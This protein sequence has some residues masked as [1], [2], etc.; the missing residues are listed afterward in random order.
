MHHVLLGRVELREPPGE[1]VL[2]DQGGSGD[3]VDLVLVG[4][5]DV[6]QRDVGL[7]GDLHVLGRQDLQIGEGE[8][9]LEHPVVGGHPAELLV[10]DQLGHGRIVA[11]DGAVGV[12]AHT[13]VHPLLRERVV[14]PEPSDHRL[15]DAGDQLDAL[16]ALSGADVS[17]HDAEHAALRAVGDHPRGRR[18]GEHAAVAGAFSGVEHAQLA[19]EPEDR[20]VHVRD[21]RQDAGV[22][23]EVAGGEVVRAVD[24]QVVAGHDL[25]GVVGGQE[26]AVLHHLDVGVDLRDR[27]SGGVD[28]VCT[29]V[30]GAVDDLALQVGGVDD[31]VIHQTDGAHTGGSEVER[32]R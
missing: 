30:G 25:Q 7:V 10:V 1:G 20:A 11:A 24:D 31:V 19:L 13:H 14:Q 5:T 17:G 29:D 9:R 3:P 12:L 26:G 4:L 22:V 2:R 28:L 18:L 32:Q 16:D 23:D 8:V 21:T 27:R 15:T 6:D